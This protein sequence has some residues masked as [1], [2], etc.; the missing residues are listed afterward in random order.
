MSKA[1]YRGERDAWEC[2]GFAPMYYGNPD[3]EWAYNM[4]IEYL[5]PKQPEPPMPTIEEMCDHEPCYIVDCGEQPSLS[6]FTSAVCMCGSRQYSLIEY[7]WW[8]IK[9]AVKAAWNEFMEAD[10]E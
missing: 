4:T 1:F 3:Y 2:R 7:R 10:D 5:A 8:Q 9:A 6:F